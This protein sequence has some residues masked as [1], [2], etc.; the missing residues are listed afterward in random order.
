[1]PYLTPDEIPEEDDC[2]PL[3]IPAS[4]DW[5]AIVS[6]AL[7]ELVKEYNWE[8]LGAVTVDEAVARMQLMVD[9]YY[10]DPCGE[11]LLPEGG[12]I[13]RINFDGHPEQLVNGEWVE[14]QGDYELPPVPEREGGTA[15]EQ[16]C[17]AATNAENV[18]A[19][20]YEEVTDM[21][22]D[23]V[24]AAEALLALGVGI[25][26][27]IY[28]P[29][30]LIA[31]AVMQIALIAF[32]EFFAFM[33]F[34]TEDVWDS[35]FSEALVCMLIDCA[36]N[37]AGVVTF[38]YDCFTAK[39]RNNLSDFDLNTTQIRLGGQVLYLLSIIGIDGLNLAGSTTA[40]ETADCSYCDPSCAPYTDMMTTELGDKTFIGGNGSDPNVTIAAIINPGTMGAYNSSNGRGGGGC[41]QGVVYADGYRAEIF[42]DLGEDCV[43]DEVNFWAWRTGNSA[44]T[45]S[46]YII[47]DAETVAAANSFTGF[48]SGWDQQHIVYG[49]PPTGRYIVCLMDGN[50]AEAEVRLDDVEVITA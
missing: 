25:G 18:L 37:T 29:V 32:G 4:T 9:Q 44:V 14:P 47:T 10:D 50:L 6:G 26:L 48:W 45:R 35:A 30:G 49:S 13:I 7:T 34:L 12:A 38:D 11:C 16:I 36:T 5:L 46:T 42:V 3:L 24:S 41:V 2:R 28:A 19:T 23:D 21:F 20:L 33:D 27:A 1:M 22:N 40:I 15:E 17:L 39:I 8:Q 43:I 31:L